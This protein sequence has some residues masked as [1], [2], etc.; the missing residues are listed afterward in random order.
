MNCLGCGTLLD[1]YRSLCVDCLNKEWSDGLN[2][3]MNKLKEIYGCQ[4]C[5]LCSRHNRMIKNLSQTKGEN[6]G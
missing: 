4:R 5:D 6:N 2:Q 1:G 3:H